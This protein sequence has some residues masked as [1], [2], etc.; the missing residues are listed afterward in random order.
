ML[1]TKG[2][3]RE[4]ACWRSHKAIH[5]ASS[6]NLSFGES[7]LMTRETVKKEL[8][9]NGPSKDMVYDRRQ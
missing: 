1:Q 3:L 2:L 5:V 6:N 8:E 4:G 7:W 9:L